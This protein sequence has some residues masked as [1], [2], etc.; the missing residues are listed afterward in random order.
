MATTQKPEIVNNVSEIAEKIQF[1][2]RA[3][4]SLGRTV[5]LIGAGCSISAGIPGASDIARR[6]VRIAAARFGCCDEK[7]DSVEAYKNLIA[8]KLFVPFPTGHPESDP[9]DE[10]IDWYKVYDG[11]F[12]RHFTAPDDV[13]E[14]F[15]TLVVD[16][17]QAINWAHLCLGEIVAQKYVSTVLTTNFDQL[18]L[19]G[20]VP[21]GVLPVV[22][23]G[24]EFF[25]SY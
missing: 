11:M 2:R 12:S 25:K 21:A 13:R 14:L 18:V 8:Q 15:A 9:T 3:D 20:M 17:K 16:A 5:F 7:A 4:G 1:A 10:T 24:I 19:S 23:D 6:M 22:C